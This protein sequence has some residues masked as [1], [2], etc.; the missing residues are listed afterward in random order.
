M[1]ARSL[2]AAEAKVRDVEAGGAGRQE[3]RDHLAYGERVLEAVAAEADGE[4]E[5]VYPRR[6][7]E[8][9]A[10]I[11]SKRPQSR[12]RVADLGVLERRHAAHSL[13]DGLLQHAPVHGRRVL[14]V[15]PDVAWAHQ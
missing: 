3:L 5:P 8:D 11:G 6:P 15:R 14:R 7:V 12:P 1:G 4:V 13:L 2:E 9:A 10:P